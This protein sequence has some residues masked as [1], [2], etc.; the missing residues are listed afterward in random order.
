MAGLPAGLVADHKTKAWIAALRGV[1]AI[2]Q[3]LSA[4]PL[5]NE[6]RHQHH[7]SHTRHRF[8]L[9]WLNGRTGEAWV[10]QQSGPE[11]RTLEN[12]KTYK[13]LAINFCGIC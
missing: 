11:S 8:R 12:Q 6:A 5:V 4:G 2:V 9:S 7:D 10:A 1:S 3:R 13:L